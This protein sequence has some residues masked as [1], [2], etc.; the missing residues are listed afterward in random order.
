MPISSSDSKKIPLLGPERP[1]LG[2]RSAQDPTT[3][4]PGIWARLENLRCQNGTLRVREGAAAIVS[5]GVPRA[6]GL[7]GLYSG[8]VNGA[9]YLVAAF[10]V[11]M[12]AGDPKAITGATH[13]TPIVVTCAGHGLATGEYVT[14]AG[15]VGNAA[16]NG[17][18]VA[19]VLDAN[20]FALD[21]SV[22]SGAYVSGGTA[23]EMPPV[24]C[25][26]RLTGSSWT[27]IT[28][29]ET[30]F[31]E[32]GEIGFAVVRDP[33][34]AYPVDSASDRLVFGNG[35][36]APR[37]SVLGLLGCAVHAA[38][39]VP[40]WATVAALPYAWMNLTS[41]ASSHYSSPEFRA[42][43]LAGTGFDPLK[44]GVKAT[45][46]PE[47]EAG[48]TLVVLF[49]SGKG[50]DAAAL[51]DGLKLQKEVVIAAK[52]H[53]GEALWSFVNRL[54]LLVDEDSEADPVAIAEMADEES[55]EIVTA[56]PHGLD[57]GD[58]VRIRNVV[59]VP[60]ASG[61]FRVTRMDATTFRIPLDGSVAGDYLSGGE[62]TKLA[63]ITAFSAE[64][65]A[66]VL[67][68][69]SQSGPRVGR[70]GQSI[71]IASIL[72]EEQEGREG[73]CGI[74][75]TASG[76]VPEETRNFY[77]Y[78]VATS[79]QVDGGANFAVAYFS[80]GSRAEGVALP[81]KSGQGASLQSMGGASLA[82]DYRWNPGT[83]FRTCYRLAIPG[84]QALAGHPDY[85]LVYRSDAYLAEDGTVQYGSYFLAH[86]ADG[87]VPLPESEGPGFTNDYVVS[88]ESDITRTAKDVGHLPIPA[89]R[90]FASANDRLF[91]AGTAAPAALWVSADRDPFAFRQIPEVDDDGNQ[92]PRSATYRTFGGERVTA[93]LRMQG[94]L[95]GVDTLLLWTD[96]GL[97]RLGGFDSRQ[98]LQAGRLSEVGTY[99]APG[100]APDGGRVWYLDVEGQ[101]RATN[102]ALASQSMAE[103]KVDDLLRAGD[104]SEA[105]GVAAF[106]A[107]RLFFR[108]AG[109]ASVALVWQRATGEWVLD[110]YP[111]AVAGAIAHDAAP[112]RMLVAAEAN[113]RLWRL[114]APGQT[115]E[116][117]D[118]IPIRLDGPEL[119]DGLW[120]PL[121]FG[122]I[123]VVCDGAVDTTLTTRRTVPY[124]GTT[125]L[126]TVDLTAEALGTASAWRWDSAEGGIPGTGACFSCVPRLDG[127]LPGGKR[128]RAVV[129][130]VQ[131]RTGGA[132]R[133]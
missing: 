62:V 27:E 58:Y 120:Q 100:V 14:V 119:S 8:T 48:D 77:L 81:A 54:E 111:F 123:G 51:D 72:T 82:A 85:A 115:T 130:Q 83:Q 20:T 13:A 3:L 19:T 43:T 12:A 32:D 112:R 38:L 42:F 84:T 40:E 109:G 132:D 79:G 71:A 41:G 64:S 50:Y 16:A 45:V 117:G 49:A 93:L 76:A 35:H 98:M 128:L 113:G 99:R 36:E 34:L 60:S 87:V 104:L 47:V 28:H 39:P 1:A 24:T 7:R 29:P 97:Y 114:E 10:R 95:Y 9:S 5:A 94:D 118:S 23:W 6:Q 57:T 92:E 127:A 96:R 122:S 73:W 103:H 15:V 74:R 101:V 105:Y 69:E 53:A 107:F 30:R 125:T 44:Q 31:A 21:G 80:S 129:I 121:S 116:A 90:H 89:G 126:G 131:A 86:G 78:T 67:T 91:V 108:E 68:V 65:A 4:P 133:A 17:V 124:D 22:G 25:V 63:W 110:R 2:M 18:W 11:P 56:T 106:E 66:D 26:Y 55:L 52:T 75:L 61:P 102:G 46:T 88:A 59:G 37:V 70:T 33:G